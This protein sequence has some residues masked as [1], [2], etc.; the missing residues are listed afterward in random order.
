MTTRHLVDPELLALVDAMPPM[1]LSDESL[2]VIRAALPAMVKA[3][4]LPDI[5]VAISDV[6]VPADGGARTVRCMMLRPA[7]LAANA[8][9]IL[10][11][12]GGGNVVGM[13]EMNTGQLMQWAD[14]LGC[15]ILSVDYRLA[16]ETRFPG[17]I[18]DCYAALGWIHAH[19][20]ALG[21]DRARI[22]VSGESA[23]GALA[24]GLALLARDRG[25]YAI[26]FQHLEQ[27]R[28][29]DRTSTEA[30][31][32][33]FTGEF[34]WTRESS[35]YCWIA[36]L[37]K[38][39]GGADTSPYAAPARASDLAGLPR[40]F[41]SVGAL[42]LFVD[43]CLDYAGRLIR[44][45]VPTELHVYPGCMHGFGMARDSGPARRAQADNIAAL[46]MAFALP[47]V[48]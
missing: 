48:P 25:E 30:A 44:A 18:E 2:P 15:L 14:A 16:P 29:D 6:Q 37:G 46:R 43:E 47:A 24:A 35:R 39:P 8:P 10:H 38:E 22:A 23:G 27:P 1:V 41:I 11:M 34:V 21:V 45:G 12:H 5:P 42:D 32:N 31:P 4:P 17:A 19:A 33:P 28:L 40:T 13:P 7:A 9:A 3:A 20:G 36:Q 26:C